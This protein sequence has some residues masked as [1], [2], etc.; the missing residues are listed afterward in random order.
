MSL[1]RFELLE[2]RRD[3]VIQ[4]YHAREIATARPVQVHFFAAGNTPEAAH[5][6]GM[7]NRL[8]D[9]ERR[10]VID[11]GESRGMPYVVTD[12]LAGYLDLRDWI[13]ANFA[14]PPPQAPPRAPVKS[15]PGSVDDEFFA[16]FD[17]NPAPEAAP[18]SMAGPAAYAV[19]EYLAPLDE[20]AVKE[21]SDGPGSNKLGAIPA[22]K[23]PVRD[24]ASDS[25]LNAS[26]EIEALRPPRKLLPTAVKSLLWLFLGILAALAILAVIAAFFAFRPH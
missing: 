12:R 15:K 22:D 5:L 16:L 26:I 11:R 21:I 18:V 2:L 6:L 17:S 14:A 19:P 9:D 1:D 3:G 7:M 20:K 13:T 24:S 8:P 4:T 25:L 23:A 10:R